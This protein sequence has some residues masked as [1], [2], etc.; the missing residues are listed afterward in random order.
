ML[1]GTVRAELFDPIGPGAVDPRLA[2]H[3]ELPRAARAEVFVQTLEAVVFPCLESHGVD[4]SAGRAWLARSRRRVAA[5]A[6]HGA[7]GSPIRRRHESHS[8]SLHSNAG[9][10]GP[11][12]RSSVSA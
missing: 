6:D 11:A 4:A 2:G 8:K 7:D 10:N 9:P 12:A 5:S 3:G 1:A